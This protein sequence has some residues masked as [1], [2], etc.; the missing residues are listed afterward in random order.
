[1]SGSGAAE[2]RDEVDILLVEDQAEDAD[3][4]RVAMR[5]A[6]PAARLHHARSVREALEGL[7]ERPYA[8][9]ILD[10]ML[11]GQGGF[12]ALM[13]MRAGWPEL[14]VLVLTSI[15]EDG[16]RFLCRELGAHYYQ[17]KPPHAA[18]YARFAAFVAETMA[19]RSFAALRAGS[20][21]D[22][23]GALA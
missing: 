7:R 8:L 16:P 12:Q 18:G 14:P 1:M 10:L 6:L 22:R 21:D 3:R 15:T 4:L 2:R 5:A 20:W 13:A 17:V 9:V 11:P 23:C 19:A